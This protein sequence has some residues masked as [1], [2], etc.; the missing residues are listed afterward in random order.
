MFSL[1]ADEATNNNNDK[2]FNVFAQ[3]Y[4]EESEKIE[5]AHLGSRKQNVVTSADIMDSLQSI[6]SEYKLEWSLSVLMDNGSTMRGVRGGVETLV[7]QK[8]PH[9]PNVSGDTVHM[10]NNVA[11]TL[12]NC[13]DQSCG[14]ICVR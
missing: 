13:V 12:M 9:L 7:R 8:N 1:N 4:D 3:Y 14:S 10:V 5:I 6:L 11:K 2:I